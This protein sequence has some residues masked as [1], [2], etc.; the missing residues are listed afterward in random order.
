VWLRA[1]DRSLDHARDVLGLEGVII[2]D[3][4]FTNEYD[5]LVARGAT[6]IRI[7]RAGLPENHHSHGSE[8]DWHS[9]T[10][11]QVVQNSGSVE[12]WQERWKYHH[13]HTT[14]H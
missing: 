3:L 9:F 7:E 10:P 14:T 13:E 1:L 12:E 2:D 5:F 6:I 8:I 4:R 11:D